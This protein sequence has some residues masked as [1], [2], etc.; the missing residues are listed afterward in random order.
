MNGF[1]VAAIGMLA[2]WCAGAAHGNPIA[3]AFAGQEGG[4]FGTIDLGTGVF[5]NI[6]V[7]ST[8]IVGLGVVGGTL[9]GAAEINTTLYQFNPTT[10]A[11][12]AIG[13]SGVA[14][15]NYDLFGSDL[16]TLYAVDTNG[17]LYSISSTTGA[18][19]LIGPVGVTLFGDQGLS[20]G[21]STYT[22]R[23]ARICTP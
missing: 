10:G 7:E 20:T 6:A 9:Y 14:G 15:I 13:S 3:Y 18:A 4:Y 23:M 21:S 16:S 2:A 5:G 12:T 17:N 19:T 22:S 8:E 11:L 1:R